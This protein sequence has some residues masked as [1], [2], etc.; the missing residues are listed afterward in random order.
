MSKILRL[1]KRLTARPQAT[2]PPSTTVR[3]FIGPEDVEA[4]LRLHRAALSGLTAAGPIWT[5]VRFEREF[6]DK[7][8]WS[9]EHLW[10][11]VRES[12]T[13]SG[14]VTAVASPLGTI[15]LGCDG[16]PP[17]DCATIRWLMVAPEARRR[18]IGAAGY[19]HG[20]E[21]YSSEPDGRAAVPATMSPPTYPATLGMSFRTPSGWTGSPSEAAGMGA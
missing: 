9:P 16:R 19:H 17:H 13:P 5:A 12:P 6:L 21:R 2:L 7:P 20:H 15:A 14:D 18:G 8:D 11:A 3:T 1:S 10:F 4:W